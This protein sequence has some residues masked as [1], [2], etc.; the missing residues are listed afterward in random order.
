MASVL[1][2]VSLVSEC[3]DK[4]ALGVKTTW[5]WISNR[6]QSSSLFFFSFDNSWQFTDNLVP[7]SMVEIWDRR[8]PTCPYFQEYTVN[9]GSWLLRKKTSLPLGGLGRGGTFFFGGN[10][11]VSDLLL[12]GS[13]ENPIPPKEEVNGSEATDYNRKKNIKEKKSVSTLQKIWCIRGYK[14]T[15]GKTLTL[16]M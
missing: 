15:H 8:L 2:T 1:Q 16:I 7:S 12:K 13:S 9:W 14:L 10:A 6:F 4:S 5:S 3:F 11:G